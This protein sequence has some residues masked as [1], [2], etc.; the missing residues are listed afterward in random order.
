M[1]ISPTGGYI[2]WHMAGLLKHAGKG[3]YAPNERAL[4]VVVAPGIEVS[5]GEMIS[6][7]ALRLHHRLTRPAHNPIDRIAY[8]FIDM[9]DARAHLHELWLREL[10]CW[11]FNEQGQKARLDPLCANLL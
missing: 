1:G 9:A 7:A 8:V 2:A 4:H 6:N 10:E 5:Q 11:A 3:L